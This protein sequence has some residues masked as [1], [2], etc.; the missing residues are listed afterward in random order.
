MNIVQNKENSL[1]FVNQAQTCQ[2][3]TSSNAFLMARFYLG[4]SGNVCKNHITSKI[5]ISFFVP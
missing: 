2:L 1:K 5:A 4:G 3:L